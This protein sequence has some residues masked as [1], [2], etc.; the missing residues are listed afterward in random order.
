M[1]TPV[2]ANTVKSTAK[3]FRAQIEQEIEQWRPFINN[4]AEKKYSRHGATTDLLFQ[5]C[6]PS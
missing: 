5:T 3:Q 1:T 4:L 2:S 6:F